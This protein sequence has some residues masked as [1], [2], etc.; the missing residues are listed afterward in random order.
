MADG[1]EMDHPLMKRAKVKEQA[2]DT[3]GAAQIY[4]MLLDRDPTMA[5][6]HLALGKLQNR[7][8]GDYAQAIYHYNRYLSLRPDTEK[9]AMIERDIRSAT[10]ALVGTVFSNQTA[11][12]RRVGLLERENM[13][14]RIRNNN[15]D[16]QLQQSRLAVSN[17]RV[18][19]AGLSAEAS[20]GLEQRGAPDAA[21]QPAIPTVRVEKNDTL[22]KI[23]AR[24]YGDQDRW[25]DIYAANGNILRRPEDVR[26]GQVLVAP[27]RP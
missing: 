16:A 13:V 4:Q 14:L 15:L 18:R 9:R 20:R 3:A 27:P 22:R 1:D 19:V 25:R 26:E 21:I 10:F 2:G 12:V 8:G 17:L 24:V 7:P 5:R 11:V 6:A 23:A